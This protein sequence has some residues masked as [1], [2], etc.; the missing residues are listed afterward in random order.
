VVSS[1]L[2][3]SLE[4]ANNKVETG[5]AD[6]STNKDN[7]VGQHPT[8]DVSLAGEGLL[9]L[10]Q[11]FQGL[12]QTVSNLMQLLPMGTPLL[13]MAVHCWDIRFKQTDHAFLPK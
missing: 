11:S 7:L 10:L 13:A 8:S 6:G 9:P 12:I 3:P 2:A 4:T 5:G 1:S